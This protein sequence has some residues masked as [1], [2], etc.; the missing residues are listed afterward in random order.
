MHA[1]HDCMHVRTHS[2]CSPRYDH[3][4]LDLPR[5]RMRMTID[6]RCDRTMMI[7]QTQVGYVLQSSM[8]RSRAAS[9][10]ANA[11]SALRR[12]SAP[13][14]LPITPARG[15]RALA[16]LLLLLLPAAAKEEGRCLGS[17]RR[18]LRSRPAEK[19]SFAEPE[20]LKS[21]HAT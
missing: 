20:E 3:Y 7:E 1:M 18:M 14:L 10:R 11:S 9:S 6:D 19:T 15:R 21:A 4:V 13:L 16:R 8:S 12:A 2:V 17:H 5:A